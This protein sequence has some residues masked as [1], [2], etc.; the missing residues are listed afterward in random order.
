MSS[1]NRGALRHKDDYYATPGWSVR[2][3]LPLLLPSLPAWP[4]I[5]EPS[6]GE[7]AIVKELLDAGI[8]SNCIDLVEIDAARATSVGKAFAPRLTAGAH[9]WVQVADF[10]DWAPAAARAPKRYDLIIG[11]PP[12]K[13]A[14]QFINLALSLLAPGGAVVQLLRQGFAA[15]QGRGP[16]IRANPPSMH[17]LERRP[18]FYEGAPPTPQPTL[19][20]PDE[21]DEETGSNTDSADY[22]WFVWRRTTADVFT[23]APTSFSVL[24]CEPAPVRRAA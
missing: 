8:N 1:T 2:A 6:C 24:A 22:A 14:L 18:S 10:R 9:A 20:G 13:L 7:G 5:L 4:S 21:E 11:N 12:F 19:F 23:F 15:S 3:V 17:V 16:W